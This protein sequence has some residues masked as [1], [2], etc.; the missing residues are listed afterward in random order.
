ME[1]S[2][3]LPCTLRRVKTPDPYCRGSNNCYVWS[4]KYNES[5]N[6]L[7]DDR[8]LCAANQQEDDDKCSNEINQQDEMESRDNDFLLANE[9]SIASSSVVCLKECNI[10]SRRNS[11]A[12]TDH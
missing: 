3:S 8:I 2:I 10:R 4:I 11:K 6:N 5:M 1:S 12:S 9:Q 7:S